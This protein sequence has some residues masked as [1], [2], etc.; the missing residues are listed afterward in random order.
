MYIARVYKDLDRL[1]YSGYLEKYPFHRE[2]GID[3]KVYTKEQGG[4]NKKRVKNRFDSVNERNKIPFPAELDD[5]I[6][7]HFLVTSRKV[8]TILEFGVGKS[9]KVFDHALRINKIKYNSY[10][11]DNLRGTNGF[12]CHSVDSSRKWIK[13]TRKKFQT[14]L[15]RYHHAKCQVL[16]FNS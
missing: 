5:L 15:V 2:L 14:N 7:L 16:T 8:T 6:R 9:T 10:V 4:L 3:L 12:E 13:K 11:S 1:G